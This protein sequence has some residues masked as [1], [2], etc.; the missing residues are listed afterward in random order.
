MMYPQSYTTSSKV[1][2][3]DMVET[4]S[5]NDRYRTATGPLFTKKTPSYGYRDSHYKPKTVVMFIMG[6]PTPVRRRLGRHLNIFHWQ[7]EAVLY[8]SPFGEFV[9]THFLPADTCVYQN[10]S[11][12]CSPLGTETQVFE[13]TQI[14]YTYCFYSVVTNIECN[15]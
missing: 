5:W 6:I 2:A 12:N 15:F 8:S 14:R 11:Y 9:G 4:T 3:K 1:I 13:T 7:D 10:V